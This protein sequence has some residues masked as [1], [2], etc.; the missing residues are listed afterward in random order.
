MNSNCLN[1]IRNILHIGRI[2]FLYFAISSYSVF[3]ELYKLRLGH[4]S[5][6]LLLSKKKLRPV[7]NFVELDGFEPTTPGLQSRCSPS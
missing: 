6:L 1:E 5:P 2:K 3:N 7:S 4:Q